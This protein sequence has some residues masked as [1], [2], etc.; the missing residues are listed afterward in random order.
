MLVS[1]PDPPFSAALD[2]LH[3]Q[4]AGYAIHPA[5]RKREG[6]GTRLQPP[7]HLGAAIIRGAASI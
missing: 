6:L 1:Y 7:L 4:R 2:V 5:L 3:H